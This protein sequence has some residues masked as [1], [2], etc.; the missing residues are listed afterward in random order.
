MGETTTKIKLYLFLS[1]ICLMINLA[2]CATAFATNS[3]NNTINTGSDN[4]NINATGYNGTVDSVTATFV[5]VG[6]SFVPFIGLI[7]IA[8]LNL[9]SVPML[10]VFY[11]LV[12]V[13]LSILQSFIIA[14][15]ILNMLPFFNA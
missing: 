7:N 3:T 6:T 12:T 2:I 9:A 8:T 15:I 11:I 4:T 5:G 1:F 14:L 13:I 10:M